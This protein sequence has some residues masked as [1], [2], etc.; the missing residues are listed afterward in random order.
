MEAQIKQALEKRITD[1]LPGLIDQVV[2][3]FTSRRFEHGGS[4]DQSAILYGYCNGV[5]EAYITY[6]DDV[7]FTELWKD[8]LWDS[9]VRVDEKNISFT[10]EETSITQADHLDIDTLRF[11][12]RYP[13]VDNLDAEPQITDIEIRE[14]IDA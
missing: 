12:V 2:V 5:V 7:D 8:L 6:C 9:F 13:L 10:L 1:K 14:Q 3:R 11:R 4:E